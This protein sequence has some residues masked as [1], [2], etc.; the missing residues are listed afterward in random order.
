MSSRNASRYGESQAFTD[1][2]C[3]ERGE[4]MF[5]L[6]VEHDVKNVLAAVSLTAIDERQ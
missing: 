4:I 1:R 6:L 2:S 5:S 3:E